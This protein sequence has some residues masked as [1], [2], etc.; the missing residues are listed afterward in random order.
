M[1]KILAFVFIMCLVLTTFALAGCND[2]K[3]S[4]SAEKSNKVTDKKEDKNE[5][6]KD[7][8]GNYVYTV[9][10]LDHGSVEV[11]TKINVYK[12]ID[13]DT[14][15]LWGMMRDC[16]WSA[17]YNNTDGAG[18]G[19]YLYDDK[20]GVRMETELEQVTEEDTAVKRR[21]CK[22]SVTPIKYEEGTNQYSVIRTIPDFVSDS[23][24][25]TKYFFKDN[26]EL[27]VSF[28]QIVFYAK[29]IDALSAG[30]SVP[31]QIDSESGVVNLP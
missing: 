13:K 30:V 5:P 6:E 20:G 24:A 10:T 29:Y 21:I 27:Y 12:Y 3:E 17:S 31:V 7:E 15:D 25:Q 2:S 14:V 23:D 1:R 19:V 18:E 9:D 11:H 22:F 8:Q 4:G 16:S 26:S 28:D